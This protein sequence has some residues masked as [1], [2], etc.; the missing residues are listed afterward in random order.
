MT[1]KHYY[2]MSRQSRAWIRKLPGFDR[3]EARTVV[4]S[5]Q[6]PEDPTCF[7]HYLIHNNR[8]VAA[9]DSYSQT[10][11]IHID[12]AMTRR[13]L[14]PFAELIAFGNR[15][16]AG[17]VLAA[18]Q[19]APCVPFQPTLAAGPCHILAELIRSASASASASASDKKKIRTTDPVTARMNFLTALLSSAVSQTVPATAEW[20]SRMLT[21]IPYSGMEQSDVITQDFSDFLSQHCL[22]LTEQDF[23]E[24]TTAIVHGLPKQATLPKP[25]KAD[26]LRI[27][28]L[29]CERLLEWCLKIEPRLKATLSIIEQEQERLRQSR[30]PYERVPLSL[31]GLT[32]RKRAIFAP[33]GERIVLMAGSD[34][35]M[36]WIYATLEKAWHKREADRVLISDLV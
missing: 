36:D 10:A 21:Y 35:L 1:T 24:T 30:K 34:E 14:S 3:P 32:R 8:P 28:R 12:T 13:R 26:M 2:R 17:H 20:L 23:I 29:Q 18:L 11:S 5:V 27:G 16:V 22:H 6:S 4:R 33:D 15:D 25:R 9:Y 7:I 31:D 19:A